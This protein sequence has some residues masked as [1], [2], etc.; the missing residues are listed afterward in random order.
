MDFLTEFSRTTKILVYYSRSFK[1]KSNGTF[2]DRPLYRIYT[3][4]TGLESLLQLLPNPEIYN[5]IR[6]RYTGKFLIFYA[7]RDQ[8]I[9][10][11]VCP[12]EFIVGEIVCYGVE[13]DHGV[14]TLSTYDCLE[15][16]KENLIE[17][18]PR[19]LRVFIKP[20]HTVLR[21]HDGQ[22]YFLISSSTPRKLL[23]RIFDVP[24]YKEWLKGQKGT[25]FWYQK[26]KDSETIYFKDEMIVL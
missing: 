22:N 21:R 7:V 2:E 6:N 15:F 20:L 19:Y 4:E 1:V 9:K 17:N 12:L 5:H 24:E 10:V 3:D 11:S 25:P 23:E 16:S 18:V 13:I 14:I 8:Y 26:C